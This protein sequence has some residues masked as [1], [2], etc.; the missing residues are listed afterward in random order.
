[1]FGASI[2]EAY[3]EAMMRRPS[4]IFHS[5]NVEQ[6]SMLNKSVG[7]SKHGAINEERVVILDAG[8]QYGKLIDRKVRELQIRSE[9]L[10]LDTSA[11][12]LKDFGCRAII[13][14]GGPNSINDDDAPVY[15]PAIFKMGLPILGI[16][17]GMHIIV[18]EFGG[19]V[20]KKDIREDG[21]YTVQV[22]TACPLFNG[23]QQVQTVL[24]THSD[25]VVR[26]GAEMKVCAISSSGI[27]AAFYNGQLRIYGVQFHP[28]VDITLNGKQM[29]ANFL[30]NICGLSPNFTIRS[31][32]EN[33]IQYIKERVGSNKVLMLV[34]GGVDSTVC[35]ALLRQALK[36]EQIIA[37]HIDNGFMRKDESSAVEKSLRE[38]GVDLLVKDAFFQ[39]SRGSTT[40]KV[41]GLF[42][43]RDTPML[44]QTINPEDKRKIIGDVFVKVSNEILK[45]MN[46]NAGEVFLAQGT[47]RPDL[48]ESASTMVNSTADT[49]KTHHNDTEL[50]RQLRNAGRVIEPLQDF[51]KDEVRRLG[52]ELGLP[53]HLI[54][55]HPFPGPGLAIRVLC[56]E[57]AYMVDYSDTQVIANVIVDYKNKLDKKHALLSCVTGTTNREEQETL[58]RISNNIKLNATLLPIRSVGVQGDKRTF[59]YA[60]GLSSNEQP[61]WPDIM[62]LAKLIPRIL[63][64][65]NRVCYIFGDAVKHPVQ[66]ITPTLLTKNVVGQIRQAD[67]IT[68]RILLENECTRKISQMPV[69][70]IPVHFDRDPA[71]R[72][73]SCQRSVV[74]RP[75]IT[76]DFMT[77][78]PALPGS[79][80]LPLPV[81]QQ[82]VDEIG[83][84]GGIS[85]VLLDLTSKPPGTTE[86]E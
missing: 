75:F 7:P 72:T 66:D 44:C 62:F 25:S 43:E 36:P 34:S 78:V 20:Q 81:L 49:I 52:Y 57:A 11:Q 3:E 68:N 40:I 2:T 38:L 83:N 64:N 16:C 48:I 70:L 71:P 60:V 61:N 9:I 10:P 84:L 30:V 15:D 50:I 14:S 32:R 80:Q 76:N 22:D 13:I 24:L 41:P 65:V 45:K 29:L 21:V 47:L 42:Y 4:S 28:E 55:R 6:M 56:A 59:S 33:C 12:Q 17:Y 67:S 73:P 18:K 51:H 46:L 5:L 85:R 77:G 1:M 23:L 79:D 26:L 35:A 69:V 63:H 54:E 8:S 31:R 27:T 82:M 39:F 19:I 58:S 86:W 37:V 53:A 74:L